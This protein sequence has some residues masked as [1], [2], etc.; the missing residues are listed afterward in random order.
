MVCLFVYWELSAVLIMIEID[1]SKNKSVTFLATTY[2]YFR[3]FS[4]NSVEAQESQDLS[5]RFPLKTWK[6]LN[7]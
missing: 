7:P 4:T 3:H 2:G 1:S 5:F 6:A